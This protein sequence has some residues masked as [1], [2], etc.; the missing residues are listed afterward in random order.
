M[1]RIIL[2]LAGLFLFACQ[3]ENPLCE[4]IAKSKELSTLSQQLLS[5]EE[6]PQEKQ[7][8]ILELRA[9]IDELCAPYKEMGP[10][11][12]YDMRNECIDAEM[13]NPEAQ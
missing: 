4:C 2:P 1:K 13:L 10:E 9:R 8:E 6:I 11:E 3:S 7:D 5:M 12:L